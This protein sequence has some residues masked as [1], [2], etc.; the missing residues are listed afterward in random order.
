MA[1]NDEV[2]FA[3][4]PASDKVELRGLAPAALAQALDAFAMADGM[5]RN[6]YVNRVLTEHVEKESHKTILRSR[7]LQGNPLFTESIG[8]KAEQS[9]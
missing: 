7:M 6:A 3:R 5:D 8:T 2:M 4:S 1:N 9:T